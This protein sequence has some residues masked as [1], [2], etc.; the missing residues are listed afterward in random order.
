MENLMRIAIQKSGRLSTASLQLIEECGI[1]LNNGPGALKAQAANFPAEFLFL[2]DDDIPGYVADGVAHLGI[3]GDNVSVEKR[4]PVETVQRLGFSRCRLSIAIPRNDPYAGVQDLEGRKIATSYP[5]LTADFL[6]RHGV[7]AHLHE[8]SGSV[9]IAPSIGLAD[10]VCDIVSTGS[11]LASNGLKEVEIIFRSEAVMIA[12]PGLSL[13]HRQT[14]DNLLFRIQAVQ[15]ARNTKYIL[16]NAPN[17]S[18]PNLRALL[19]GMRSPT[20]M[21]LAD[22]GW[23]SLHS[24][25]DENEFWQKIEA[26]RAAGAEGILVLPIEKMIL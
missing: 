20:V 15:R 26:L 11:T 10:A 17:E 1:H 5:N 16:L 7:Q 14:L 9:E 13:A 3:V 8:I 23:S 25:I 2:R 6:A 18:I 19:P 4:Q 12:H 24:V 22:P 21:P